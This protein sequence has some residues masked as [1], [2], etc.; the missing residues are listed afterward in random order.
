MENRVVV[1][2]ICRF[3]FNADRQYYSARC[4][5]LGMSAYGKTQDEAIDNFK[6]HFNA[7]IQAYRE[8][9]KLEGVL[10]RSGVDWWWE[11]DYP[12]DRP[13]YEDTHAT[14]APRGGIRDGEALN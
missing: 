1:S 2:L 4:W 8:G 5:E 13:A 6:R 14:P 7:A 3:D 10:T 9:G 11:G 12:A